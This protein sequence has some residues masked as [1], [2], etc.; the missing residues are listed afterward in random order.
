MITQAFNQAQVGRDGDNMKE[1]DN[2]KTKI[3]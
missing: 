1:L 2:S 3:I